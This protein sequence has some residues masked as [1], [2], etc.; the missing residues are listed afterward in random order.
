[1]RRQIVKTS[2]FSSLFVVSAI[3]H[4]GCGGQPAAADKPNQV[5]KSRDAPPGPAKTA[6]ATNTA[7]PT[8]PA[9]TAAKTADSQPRAPEP[10]ARIE[11]PAAPKMLEDVCQFAEVLDLGKL[12]VPTGG[13]I[14]NTSPTRFSANVPLAVRA[15]VDFYLAKLNALGWKP[16]G[17]S[18]SESVTDSFAQVSLEKGNHRLAMTAMPGEGKLTGVEIEHHGGLDSRTLPR[19]PAPRTSIATVPARSTL[20]QA[21]STRRSTNCGGC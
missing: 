18:L 4:S 3:L 12:P 21:R 6:D 1:M 10:V 15:A 7:T 2:L 19:L 16:V 9:K 13:T 14:G 17:P 8:T 20:P 5:A 11:P